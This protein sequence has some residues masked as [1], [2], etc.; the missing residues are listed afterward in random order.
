MNSVDCGCNTAGSLNSSCSQQTGICYCKKY[1][2][3]QKCDSCQKTYYQ[4]SQ[5]DL[6]GCI[7]CNCNLGGSINA[8]CDMFTGQCS[9]RNGIMGRDCSSVISGHFFPLP[10]YLILEAEYSSGSYQRVSHTGEEN[11]LYTGMGKASVTSRNNSLLDLGLL[12]PPSS[13]WY[14]ATF[15][16]SL[17]GQTAWPS[18]T[19]EILVGSEVGNG[20]PSCTEPNDKLV[21][22]YTQWSVGIRTTIGQNVCLRGGRSYHFVLRAFDGGNLEPERALSIDSFFLIPV[23]ISGI[24]VFDDIAVYATYNTCVNSLKIL[25]RSPAVLNA[26]KDVIFEVYTAVYNGT[27]RKCICI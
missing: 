18:A 24:T 23:Y 27:L 25:P 17:Q 22:L 14:Q 12:T 3:G 16:Y 7:P 1:V 10:D 6:E 8:Q 20:I 2:T 26:C 15:R 4:L 13:G 11:T 21:T 19:L 9:C 5:S